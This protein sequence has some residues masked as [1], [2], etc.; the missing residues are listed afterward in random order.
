MNKF[1][2]YIIGALIIYA[3]IDNKIA[4][5]DPHQDKT[6]IASSNESSP[7]TILEGNILEKSLSNIIINTLKTPEGRTFF[8]NM[9]QPKNKSILGEDF[10]FKL[11]GSQMVESLFKIETIGEQGI[12]PVSCG[13]IVHAQYQILTMDNIIVEE[14]KK[15]FRIGSGEMIQGLDNVIIGMY[16][17]Q[18][19]KAIIPANYAYL[20]QLSDDKKPGL[21]Y[22]VNVTLI[23]I[24]PKT[25]VSNV[26]IFDDEIAY[27][28][29]CLCGSRVSFN[30]LIS[31]INGE[32]IY[33]SKAKNKKIEMILGDLSYPMIISHGLTGKI[34]V[35][36]R[37][38]ISQGKYFRS[39]GNAATNNIFQNKQ[40]GMD[41]YFLIEFSDLKQ[42]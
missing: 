25:F 36:K 13:H 7:D 2:T 6:Q 29:P 15:T 37:T 35:G 32:V 42:N 22:Q 30:M 38:I 12:G 8:E 5:K 41:E 39:L 34:P 3:I 40:L 20:Q 14:G 27:K 17:G 21:N 10:G 11:N 28:A 18:N 1:L 4:S 9:I 33:D 26:K 23:D 16:V 24:I 31:K 19:R